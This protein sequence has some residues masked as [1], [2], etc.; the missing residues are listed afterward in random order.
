MGAAVGEP[1]TYDYVVVGAG[2]AGCVLANRLSADP[3][4]SVLP[5]E[6]GGSERHPYVSAPA[7][8]IKTFHDP[9]FNWCLTT[10]PGDGVKGRAIHFPQGRVLGGS[11]AINGHLYVR[12]QARDF[13]TRAQLGNRGWSF[14]DVLPYFKRSEDRSTGADAYHGAGGAPHASDIQERHPICEAFLAGAG[15]LGLPV[16]PDYNGASQEGVAYYQRTIRNGRRRSA[17]HAFLRPAMKRANLRVV[18]RA[19]ASGITFA[20]R[21]ATGVRYRRAGRSERALAGREVILAAGAIGSPHLPQRSGIGPAPLLHDLGIPVRHALPGV[22]EGFRDH[23][24]VR[25]AS[26]VRNATTLNERARGARLIREVL[27]A[28]ADD[29]PGA[30]HRHAFEPALV[31][32]RRAEPR[33]RRGDDRGRLNLQA[34]HP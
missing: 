21:R 6:A 25:V 12:G 13:D 24:S 3:R 17:A 32:P 14:D 31:A 9:R 27:P 26:R 22:G 2:A 30:V 15:E 10:E 8:F 7:G 4:V 18:T 1:R 34:H 33:A 20:G 23:Y 16:N 11:S 5:L 19:A 29:E 28:D